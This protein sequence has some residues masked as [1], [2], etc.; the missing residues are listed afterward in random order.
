MTERC[1]YL[2]EPLE[3]QRNHVCENVLRIPN[4]IQ[5]ESIPQC[6]VRLAWGFVLNDKEEQHLHLTLRARHSCP[7]V[8]GTLSGAGWW[9]GKSRGMG[10]WERA[11]YDPWATCQIPFMLNPQPSAHW[12]YV[13]I[14]E[15]IT[16]SHCHQGPPAL[17]GNVG[18]GADQEFFLTSQIKGPSPNFP[19]SNPVPPLG[20]SLLM[21]FSLTA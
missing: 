1:D 15:Q 11:D 10:R 19:E 2:T 9:N 17:G 5:L 7:L 16:N 13:G 8:L 4:C 20:R 3:N 14:Q 18:S 6:W 21:P 12:V